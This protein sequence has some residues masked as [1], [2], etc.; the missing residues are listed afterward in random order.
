MHKLDRCKLDP[1]IPYKYV[2]KNPAIPFPLRE[3]ERERELKIKKNNLFPAKFELFLKPK[4]KE[5]AEKNTRKLS[6]A[7]F[8]RSCNSSRSLKYD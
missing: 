4:R 7:Q 2:Y 8:R 1:T 5:V 3:R 6:A